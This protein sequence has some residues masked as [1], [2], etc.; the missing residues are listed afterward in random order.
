MLIQVRRLSSVGFLKV[1]SFDPYYLHC[2]LYINDLYKVSNI[3]EFIIFADDTNIVCIGVKAVDVIH[4]I[5][6]ELAKLTECLKAN[7]LSLNVQKI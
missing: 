3:L 7:K 1:L 4:I 5:N 6:T 2:I